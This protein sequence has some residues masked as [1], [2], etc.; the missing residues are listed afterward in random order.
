MRIIRIVA[1]L[2]V[3]LLALIGL[4]VGT[5]A[6]VPVRLRTPY[7][8]PVG[9]TPAALTASGSVLGLTLKCMCAGQTIYIGSDSSVSASTGWP[10]YDG[11]TFSVE[12]SDAANVW[13]VASAAG[14][15]LAVLPYR[16]N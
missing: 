7:Q 6:Q 10:L 12:V 5:Q 9:M 13:A 8:V 16:R 15:R 2:L 4:G 3:L 14:Q 11:D 1:V